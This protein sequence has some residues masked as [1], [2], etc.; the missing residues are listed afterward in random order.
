MKTIRNFGAALLAAT[1]LGSAA[2][3]AQAQSY[4]YD[5]HSSSGLPVSGVFGYINKVWVTE[6]DEGKYYENFWGEPDKRLHG[7]QLGLLYKPYL[8]FGAGLRTGLALEGCTSTS[9]FV[10]DKGWDTFREASLYMPLQVSWRIPLGSSVSITPF[11]G[12]GFNWAM[13]GSFK[14]DNRYYYDYDDNYY[15]P[16]EFQKYGNG[17]APKRWNN[18]LEWGADLRI[19]IFHLGFT[20]SQGLRDHELYKG[21]ETYQDKISITLGLDLSGAGD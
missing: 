11:F 3:Q 13:Y 20:Y 2:Q 8:P 5:T 9:D 12:F 4:E 10:H 15:G 16:E 18:Q 6:P 7:F 17:V 19:K 21:F 14:D 1:I